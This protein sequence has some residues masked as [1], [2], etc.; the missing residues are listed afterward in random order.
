[1]V[2]ES[3]PDVMSVEQAGARLGLSRGTAYEA[4]RRGELPGIFRIGSRWMVSIAA[5]EAAL[6]APQTIGK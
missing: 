5:F 1:M 6:A 3:Q 2:T 4:A